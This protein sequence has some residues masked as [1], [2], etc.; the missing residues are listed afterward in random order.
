M[1]GSAGTEPAD[2][3]AAVVGV[4]R[5][6]LNDGRAKARKLLD[7]EHDGMACATRLSDLMDGLVA[8]SSG[9][10]P[11]CSTLSTTPPPAERLAVVAVGGYG[12][13]TLAP[14]SDVDLLFLLPYK[15]TP[16]GENVVETILYA[17]WDLE[18][19]VGH[20][21]R[22]VDECLREARGDMTIRTALLEARL[23]SG[24]AA[25]F[26]ELA[27]RFDREVVQ[28]TA[29]EFVAAKLAERERASSPRRHV[30]LSRRA[31]RQGRQGR[32]ARPQHAVLDRQ[33]R[34]PRPGRGAIWSA[35]AYST[36]K[37]ASCSSAATSSCGACA[38]RCTSSPAAPRS[39]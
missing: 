27:D 26:A 6:V 29:A 31:Q 35:P 32:A 3:R 33:I 28:G 2:R 8:H 14:G 21:T 23:M 7:A 36:R 37:S 20:A 38:A 1:I 19:K 12:R 5:R 13:G 4:L 39:G 11:P 17:L 16:W 24:D 25:L 34:L 18:L 15:P 10:R 22:T 9:S 30:A